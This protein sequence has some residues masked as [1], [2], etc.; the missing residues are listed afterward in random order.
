MA[1]MRL[2]TLVLALLV[3]LAPQ[4]GGAQIPRAAPAPL[5]DLFPADTI[6]YLEIQL[7]SGDGKGAPLDRLLADLLGQP[8]LAAQAGPWAMLPQLARAAALGV[9]AEGENVHVMGVLAADNPATLRTLV[10]AAAPG[11]RQVETYAGV[12]VYAIEGR[13]TTFLA[14]TSAYLIAANDRDAL[15][16]VLDRARAG[17]SAPPGLAASPRYRT[18]IGRLPASRVVTGYV[19][20]ENL[21]TWLG[22]RGAQREGAPFPRNVPAAPP[23]LDVPITPARQTGLQ[24]AL[25]A[26]ESDGLGLAVQT[27]PEGLR[28]VLVQPAPDERA[29]P[30]QPSASAALGLVPADA[31]VAVTSQGLGPLLRE[32]LARSA[33]RLEELLPPGLD[34][35][36]DLFDWMDGE[37]GLTLL[38]PEVAAHVVDDIPLPTIALLFEVRDPAQPDDGLRHLAAVAERA[39]WLPSGVPREEQQAGLPVRRLPLVEGLELTWGALGSWFF[40]TTGSAAPLASAAA[41]GGLAAS[42]AYARLVRELPS[43][44]TGIVYVQVGDT[45]RWVDSLEDDPLARLPA[46]ERWW[47]PLV[48]RLGAFVLTSGLPRDG[49]LEQVSILEVMSDE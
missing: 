7:R 35:N 2:G 45:V 38:A 44:N 20:S 25:A 6:G 15:A 48:A 14:A 27:V 3:A 39:G 46:D 37:L 31:L 17:P 42:P 40:V 36:A 47:R 49:W 23:G 28:A 10:L 34:L 24:R 33:E 11:A 16:G 4:A 29:A 8:E 30:A 22:E 43:P 5:V 41:D 32:A 12:P 26:F 19:D 9:A 1:G 21:L 13:H 18:T